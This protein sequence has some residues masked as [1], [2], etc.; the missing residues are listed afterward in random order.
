MLGAT[1]MPRHAQNAVVV[2]RTH[3]VS[4]Y[5][6]PPGTP[7]QDEDRPLVAPPLVIEDGMHQL[8]VVVAHQGKMAMVRWVWMH[9]SGKRNRR[10]WTETGTWVRKR[11]E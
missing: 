8:R 2:Q 4:V 9:E 5:P 11:A 7:L 10:V 6:T 1:G 3:L